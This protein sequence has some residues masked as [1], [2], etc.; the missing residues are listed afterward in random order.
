[1]I[2]RDLESMQGMIEFF[3]EVADPE[4]KLGVAQ[5]VAREVLADGDRIRELLPPAEAEAFLAAQAALL[6][7]EATGTPD[8]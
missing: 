6:G 7:P 8:R 1:M 5:M 2:E 4:D 3:V